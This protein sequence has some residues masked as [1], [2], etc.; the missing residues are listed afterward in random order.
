MRTH[1]LDASSATLG[2]V[3][4][5]AAQLL[6]GKNRPDFER[7]VKEPVRLTI[8]NSDAI[9]FTGKKWADKKYYRHS[10]YL[11]NLKEIT[12]GRMRRTDSRRLMRL[13]VRG[14]LPK[15]RLARK[16]IKNL[17]IY[18]GECKAAK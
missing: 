7:H 4:S 14:M 10:G 2:R 5:Q 16:M 13:A 6:M 15:N 12:A 8:V 9:I 1:I 18:K 17:E 3:A 11:G